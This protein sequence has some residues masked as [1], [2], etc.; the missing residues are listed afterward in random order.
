MSYHQG[1]FEFEIQF[2]GPARRNDQIAMPEDGIGV[3]E[4]K[5]R[6]LVPLRDHVQSAL[7]SAGSHVLFEGI[8]IADR[9]NF[10]YIGGR[11]HR[12]FHRKLPLSLHDEI[13][14]AQEHSSDHGRG[15]QIGSVALRVDFQVPDSQELLDRL[16]VG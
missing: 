15:G 13:V 10:R 1:D 2:E 6:D 5:N 3:R 8:E 7:G 14:E 4:V 9:A 12:R 16:R 11:F